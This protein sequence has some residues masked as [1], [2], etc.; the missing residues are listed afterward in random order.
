M[1]TIDPARLLGDLATLRGFGRFR[2]GVHRPTLSPADVEARRWLVARLQEAGLDARIDGIASVFGFTRN[3]GRRLL[4]GSHLESQNEAGWLDGALGVICALEIARALPGLPIDVVAF[5]DEEGHFGSFLGSR[6]FIGEVTEAEIDAARCRTRGVALRDALKQAGLDGV[7]RVTL[8]DPS[9]YLGFLE[10]HVEQGDELEAKGLRLGVVTS[11]VAIW[12]FRIRCAG[13]QNHAGTTRM[14]IR[15]DAGVAMVRLANRI[16]D[17]MPQVV[18][19]RSVWTIGRISLDPN[20]PSIIPGGAEMNVQVRDADP[21]VLARMEAHLRALVAEADAAGPC[22]VTIEDGSKGI[23]KVMDARL[24]DALAAA[25]EARAPG[26]WQRMPSGAGHDAQV[27]AL[28]MQAG[29]LFVPSIGGISHHWSED[30]KEEDIVLGCAVL[31]DA[32]E[33]LVKG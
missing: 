24:Q 25:A 7:P 3:P 28:R 21:A 1:A 10:A 16:H 17:T 14:A 31:A 8:D 20:A 27:V 4:I 32:A 29:M 5:A 11:I 18:A 26:A 33:A 22:R 6:S 19:E 30:T 23:P 15:K 2:T 9:R 12:N 13:V